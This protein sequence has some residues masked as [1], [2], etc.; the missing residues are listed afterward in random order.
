MTCHRKNARAV[1]CPVVRWL[2]I[3]FLTAFAASTTNGDDVLGDVRFEREGA[4]ATSSAYPPAVFSHWI[5]RINY[6]C[7]TCHDAIFKMERGATPVSMDRIAK[8]ETCGVCHN[9]EQAFA[10]DFKNCNRCHS[11]PEE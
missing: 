1:R 3:I 6:R 5:H 10:T 7:D 9:G 2:G 8:R 4:M 11:A